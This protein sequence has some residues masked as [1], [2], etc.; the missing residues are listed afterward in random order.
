MTPFAHWA[1]RSVPQRASIARLLCLCFAAWVVPAMVYVVYS[2]YCASMFEA[3][4]RARQF[5]LVRIPAMWLAVYTRRHSYMIGI[6]ARQV[7]TGIVMCF[8]ALAC[9]PVWPVMGVFDRYGYWKL[10]R[11]LEY[12]TLPIVT[13]WISLPYRPPKVCER[14]SKH[15]NAPAGAHLL[16]HFTQVL[17][18][19]Y[20]GQ[21]S[22]IAITGFLVNGGFAPI[23]SARRMQ[24]VWLFYLVNVGAAYGLMHLCRPFVG[25][26][27]VSVKMAL[28]GGGTIGVGRLF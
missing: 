14:E 23:S 4:I 19:F 7:L 25:R 2:R 20:L 26:L 11:L 17:P 21:M 28:W 15:T 18:Y 12:A 24:W 13:V 6:R 22:S 5:P 8:V 9:T 1:W 10:H 3:I 16:A 27:R